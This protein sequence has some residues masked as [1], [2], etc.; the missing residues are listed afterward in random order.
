MLHALI[1]AFRFC[2][3]CSS[4]SCLNLVAFGSAE[5]LASLD[6][7]AAKPLGPRPLQEPDE[8]DDDDDKPL[9]ELVQNQVEPITSPYDGVKAVASRAA[10]GKDSGE[11]IE[12]TASFFWS[13]RHCLK[14]DLTRALGLP[15]M[16]TAVDTNGQPSAGRSRLP[17]PNRN[18]P[19][20]RTA[21]F[22]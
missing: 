2:I 12:F 3:D 15:T 21:T 11:Y 17:L 14:W 9:S 4:L 20:L 5:H 19:L 7:G 1:H 13:H 18:L 6:H 22:G 16:S 8:E 10:L